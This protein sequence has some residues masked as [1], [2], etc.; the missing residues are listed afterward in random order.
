[1]RGL[2]KNFTQIFKRQ[3]STYVTGVHTKELG[4]K[5]LIMDPST[6]QGMAFDLQT[7]QMLGM[8][9]LLPPR[10]MEQEEQLELCWAAF[11]KIQTNI[12][13]YGWMSDLCNR[14]EK[15]YYAMLKSDIKTLLPIVYTPTV[16]EACLNYGDIFRMPRGMWIS[17][18]D[19]GYVREILKNWPEKSIRAVV[20]TDGER[21]LGLG[22]LGAHGMGIPVG[23]LALYT[24]CAGLHPSVCLPV[25]IDVGTD[26]EKLLNDPHYIGL[27]QKRVRGV[28]YEDL[29]DEFMESVKDIFGRLTLI[30]FEDFG[31]HNA[32]KFLKKYRNKYCCFNDDIQ[33]TAA[34]ALSGLIAS[35]QITGIKPQHQKYLF[36][37][38]GEA[39]MGIAQL[40]RQ[41]LRDKG[42]PNHEIARRINFFD[43]EGLICSE[44]SGS[45]DPDHELYAHDMPFTDN[46]A[47]A[48]REVQPT[49]IIGVAGAGPLFTEEVIREMAKINERPII[50]ALSNPTSRAEC[51]AE[52]AYNFTD[53]RCVYA[54]GSPQDPVKLNHGPFEGETKYPGQGNNVY[55]FPG[56]AM[57][58]VLSGVRHI[59]S[60]AFLVA[61]R[62]VANSV[63]KEEIERGQVYPDLER[64]RDVSVD[65]AADVMEYIYS[66]PASESL[67]SFLPEPVDKRAYVREHCYQTDYAKLTPSL[68]RWPGEQ[69]RDMRQPK[70]FNKLRM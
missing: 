37:G 63:S 68:W 69:P 17:I 35:E 16:G 28:E 50:F 49:A 9:G 29:I 31:N 65:V 53:G 51:T 10:Q 11:N 56:V 43:A 1:M 52:E 14:N 42:V 24:A 62:T 38:A 39:G 46:F 2:Q 15:L 3:S 7:R 4:G 54:T 5:Q 66:A 60:R 34:C 36:L 59:P 23:K 57:A 30:Q 33:G 44:R 8:H 55:I 18:N 67:A 32:F 41:Q 27:K 48:V 58:A 26:N 19:K 47:E 12:E 21:I 45:L 20:V 13:K 25:C 70:Y 6:N 22:D 61:A 64:I 40:L